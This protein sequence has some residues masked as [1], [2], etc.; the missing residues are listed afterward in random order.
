MEKKM[1]LNVVGMKMENSGGNN[2]GKME[3]K[4]IVQKKIDN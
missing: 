3:E 4:S 1:V 2:I